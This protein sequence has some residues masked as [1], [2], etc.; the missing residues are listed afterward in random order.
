VFPG[1]SEPP[2]NTRFALERFRVVDAPDWAGFHLAT[3]LE[4]GQDSFVA[5]RAPSGSPLA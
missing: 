5:P 2:G 4:L 1:G 3:T